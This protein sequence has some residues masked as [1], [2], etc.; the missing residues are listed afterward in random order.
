MPF[1]NQLTPDE[2]ELEAQ[3]AGLRPAQPAMERDELMFRAGQATAARRLHRWQGATSLMGLA[4]LGVWLCQP[5]PLTPPQPLLGTI[6]DPQKTE[7]PP[8]PT[9]APA[10]QP[11][12]RQDPESPS[13]IRQ[14]LALRSRV[15]M[16]GVDALPVPLADPQPAEKILST[17][18]W[19]LFASLAPPAGPARLSIR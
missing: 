3:L 16:E 8:V 11:W 10:A 19:R 4:L 2:R 15:I 13:P 17:T 6:P 5:V 14:Y 12:L 18:D 1:E 9:V 7:E